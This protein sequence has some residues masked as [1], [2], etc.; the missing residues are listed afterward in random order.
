MTKLVA[1]DFETAN[2]NKVSAISLGVVV[3]EDGKETAREVMYFCPPTGDEFEFTYIHGITYDDVKDKPLFSHYY[4]KLQNYFDGAVLVAHNAS[5]DLEVL[6]ECC[7]HYNLSKFNNPCLDTVPV[8]RICLPNLENHKLST[9]CDRLN[10]PLNHHEALSDAY[11]CLGI[12]HKTME[13]T[14]SKNLNEF[15][16]YLYDHKRYLDGYKYSNV[17]MYNKESFNQQMKGREV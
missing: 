5:F 9:V 4:E 2:N 6:N 3:T 14:G 17:I 11:G 8:T 7:R 1:F 12:V 15:V 16:D 13:M 10:I